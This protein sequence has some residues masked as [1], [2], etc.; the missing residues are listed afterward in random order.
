MKKKRKEKKGKKKKER[1]ARKRIAYGA[2]D[3][4]ETFKGI[5]EANFRNSVVYCLNRYR[6]RP[7]QGF[8]N[9]MES[10]GN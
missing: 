5:L 2:K 10:V 9:P 6:N 1:I 4:V 3:V 8:E 7:R